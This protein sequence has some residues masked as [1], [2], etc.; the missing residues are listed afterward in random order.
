MTKTKK[1]PKIK[2]TVKSVGRVFTS[3]GKTFEEAVDK[4]KIPNG[5]RALSILTV[6]QGDYKKEKI[7][8]ASHT[9]GLFGQGSP[10]ARIIH[11]KSVRNMLGV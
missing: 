2:L 3:E 4:I 1:T 11:L 7:L 9:N 5:A 10:T 8:N 6:E